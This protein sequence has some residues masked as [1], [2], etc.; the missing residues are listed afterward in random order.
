MSEEFGCIIRFKCEHENSIELLKQVSVCF[1]AQQFDKARDL[2]KGVELKRPLNVIKELSDDSSYRNIAT[3]LTVC[4]DQSGATLGIKGR[5]GMDNISKL[6]SSKKGVYEIEAEGVDREAHIFCKY[7]SIF[8]YA[9]GASEVTASGSASYWN[10]EWHISNDKLSE[11]VDWA[12][13]DGWE[14]Y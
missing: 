4:A 1:D 2:L 6:K 8:I 12:E 7:L 14:E 11:S 5:Y 3:A 13:E 9:L 10:G